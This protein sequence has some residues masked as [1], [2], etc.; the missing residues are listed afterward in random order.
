M[1]ESLPK[2]S[3]ELCDQML[4][5]CLQALKVNTFLD[6]YDAERYSADGVD[7]SMVFESGYHGSQFK[8]FF[9]NYPKLFEAMGVL[10]GDSSKRIFLYLIA[11]RLAGFHS[12]RLPV[13]F[14][15]ESEVFRNYISSQKFTE[16]EIDLGGM[17][18]KLKHFDFEHENRRYVVDCLG[19]QFY[20]FRNQYFYKN[21]SVEIAPAEGDH[22]IDGGACLGDTAIVFGN[23]VG[24]EGYVYC[25]DPVWEHLEVLRYNSSQN[26]HLNIKIFPYGVSDFDCECEPLRVNSY[27]PGFRALNR[28]L[29]MRAI[30][31]L[32]INGDISRVDF[33]KL[34]VEGAELGALK[35]ASGTIRKFKP[36]MAVSVYHRP[37]DIFELP[38]WVREN[39]PDYKIYLDHYTIHNEE[40]VIYCST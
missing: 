15:E 20:L 2:S 22:V 29:P 32:V 1:F 40:T 13:G 25:F 33:I 38:L 14:S 12:V 21:S 17:F 35:G 31:T 3:E 27:S 18:G 36:K 5:E 26:P 30:D 16:S 9:R 7:R 11:Y 34:D 6:N 4:A 10:E 39:F 23:A 28:D 37:N 8:W 24:K 19:L